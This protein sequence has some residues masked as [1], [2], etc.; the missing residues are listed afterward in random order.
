[1]QFS[2]LQSSNLNGFFISLFLQSS[3]SSS[4]FELKCSIKD[5]LNSSLHF[6]QPI[7]FISKVKF[8]IFSFSKKS[9]AKDITSN[10]AKGEEGP[11]TSTPN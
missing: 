1:M 2:F 3:Q 9:I 5:F 11:K 6:K 10:S 8:S 4:F 7:E